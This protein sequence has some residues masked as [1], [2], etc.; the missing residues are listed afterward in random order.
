MRRAETNGTQTL[1]VFHVKPYIRHVT[2]VYYSG[3]VGN[4]I[5][6]NTGSFSTGFEKKN[7][8]PLRSGGSG[9]C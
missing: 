4:N 6:L 1:G 7:E 2:H 9:R 3:K 5:T 8:F